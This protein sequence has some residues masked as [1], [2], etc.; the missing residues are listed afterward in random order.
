MSAP[1]SDMICARPWCHRSSTSWTYYMYRSY[2]SF[3]CLLHGLFVWTKHDCFIDSKKAS[4]NESIPDIIDC[5]L[6]KDHQILIVLVRVYL[7]Q[8]VIKRLLKL[9]PHP[10]SAF[11]LPGKNKQAKYVLK[12]TKK[13]QKIS[14]LQICGFNSPDLSRVEYNAHDMLSINQSINQV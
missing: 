10:T 6:K 5:N 1:G 13:R 4:K 2:F 9:P 7:T 11:A 12:W 3:Y 14:L 8:L